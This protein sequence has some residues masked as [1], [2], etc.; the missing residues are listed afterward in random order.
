[1][2]SQLRHVAANGPPTSYLTQIIFVA[3]SAI[4]SAIPLEPAARIVRMNPTFVPPFR[5]RLR[6]VHVKIIQRGACSIRRKL[7]ALEPVRRKF[8]PA[9][10]HVF[11]AEDTEAQHSNYG[12]NIRNAPSNSDLPALANHVVV[13]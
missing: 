13:Q 10:G 8:F 2:F 5:K 11:S 4:I 7:R 3:A 6:R 12:T 1:M 9:I